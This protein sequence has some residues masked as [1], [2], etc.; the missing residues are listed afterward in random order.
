MI[1]RG[2]DLSLGRKWRRQSGGG[3]PADRTIKTPA[4]GRRIT[5]E[6]IWGGRKPQVA[7]VALRTDYDSNAIEGKLRGLEGDANRQDTVNFPQNLPR[8]NKPVAVEYALRTG[9]ANLR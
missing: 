5:A 8:N 9:A 3:L 1:R 4:H 6:H 7:P 2:G